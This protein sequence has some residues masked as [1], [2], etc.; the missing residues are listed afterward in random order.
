MTIWVPSLAGHDGPIYQAIADELAS[1]VESGTLAPGARLPAQRDLAHELGLTVTTVTRGYAEARRRGLINSHV[2][3]GSFVRRPAPLPHQLHDL[4]AHDGHI[5]CSVSALLPTAHADEIAARFRQPPTLDPMRRVGY[6]PW[7]GTSRDRAAGAAWIGRTGLDVSPDR[8]LVT[9]GAQHAM[10]VAFATLLTPGDLVVTEE[11]TYGGLAAVAAYLRVRVEGL[12]MDDEGLRPDALDNACRR[13]HPKLLY[14]VPSAQN[15]TGAVMSAARRRE[16]ARVAAAH[17]LVIVEDDSYGLFV[18]GA[19]P[20]AAYGPSRA[21]YITSTSKTLI[22][23]LRIGYLVA[24]PGPPD[25][26]QPLVPA[27]FAT[28]VMA[29]PITAE[30]ASDWIDGGLADRILAWKRD[31]A[32]ARNRLART[33]LGA[34]DLSG[35][36]AAPHVLLRLPA[37]WRAEDFEAQARR[38]GVLVDA[39]GKFAV[40]RAPTP[41]A[42]R[43]ALGMPPTRAVLERG[44]RVLADIL[45]GSPAS[46]NP[47]V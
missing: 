45:A 4:E 11:L 43:V 38:Q 7:V 27:M 33:V 13:D 46:G 25:M 21:Y 14:C 34:F 47:I 3:R 44:L 24:P 29:S 40:G 8:V 23:A 42:I 37:P 6:Q 17:D 39:A 1:D 12:P 26:V 19:K 18:D 16:V 32:A 2:G 36:E 22:P 35:H 15:P 20:L 30:I 10:Q 9:A 5:D 31:E 28:V 41:R